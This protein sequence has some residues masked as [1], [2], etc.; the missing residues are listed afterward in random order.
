VPF[1]N[2]C[3]SCGACCAYFRVSFCWLEGNPDIEDAVP[4]DLTEDLPPYRL[5]MRGTNQKNPRCVALVGQIGAAVS[6]AIYQNR[7]S[8]CREFGIQ[9][10]DEHISASSEDIERCN[11]A[12]AVWGLYPIILD[13]HGEQRASDLPLMPIG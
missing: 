8:P 4:L 6:C 1:G 7:P 3:L 9:Y 5:C 13:D 10:N 12:R 2:P 11:R